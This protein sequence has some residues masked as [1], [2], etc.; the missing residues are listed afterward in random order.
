MSFDMECEY[1]E[2]PLSS[3]DLGWGWFVKGDQDNFTLETPSSNIEITH[4]EI[5]DEGTHPLVRNKSI[6]MKVLEYIKH[7]TLIEKI[8]LIILN[9]FTNR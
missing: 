1:T 4:I 3:P 7:L 8:Y 2:S 6:I 9:L 5:L